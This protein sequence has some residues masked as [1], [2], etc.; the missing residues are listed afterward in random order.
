[1]DAGIWRG[2]FEDNKKRRRRQVYYLSRRAKG[3]GARR[4]GEGIT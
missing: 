4:E 1:M 3:I 2:I